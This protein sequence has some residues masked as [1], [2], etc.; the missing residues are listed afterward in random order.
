MP[1][2]FTQDWFTQ[3]IPKWERYLMPLRE[4]D[5]VNVLEIGCFEGRATK[6]LLENILVS[7]NSNI[8]CV[9]TFTG[10]AEH[11]EETMSGVYDRF[12]EN[13]KEWSEK[14]DLRV[15]TSKDWLLALVAVKAQ[16]D[17]IYIDGS[18]DASD[19]MWDAVMSNELLRFGGILIFDD[20][21]WK[22]PLE[23]WETPKPAIESFYFCFQDEYEI[24]DEGYQVILQK[25]S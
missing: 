19:V 20:Y 12:M 11:S 18:H 8:T 6:W 24:I 23:I 7:D 15:G 16:F 21:G 2:N 1:S 13:T 17:L 9:D 4:L 10:G 14:I 25:T 3:N 5:K 22:A